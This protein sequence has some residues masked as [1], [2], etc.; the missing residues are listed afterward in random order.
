MFLVDALH[1]GHRGVGRA[2]LGVPHRGGRVVAAERAEVAVPVDERQPH[3]PWLSQ[4]D[5]GIVDRA[6]AVRVQAAH[7]VAHDAGA[8]DVAAVRA[9]PHLVHLVEDAPLYRLEAVAVRERAGVDDA[10]GVLQVGAAHLLGDVD[11]DDVLRT[12]PG[13]G[14][15]VPPRRGGMLR[16]SVGL[17]CRLSR[18]RC[19]TGRA[20]WRR[21]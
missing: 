15:V 19:G 14:A 10:V 5:Q 21:R 8:L 20:R 7:D 2:A 13:G 12:L 4:P 1:H 16:S 11:V 6:V 9:Q 17:I 3:R 18:C